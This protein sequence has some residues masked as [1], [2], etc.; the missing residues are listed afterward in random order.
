MRKLLAVA[1]AGAAVLVP[2]SS[3]SAYV[4]CVLATPEGHQVCVNPPCPAGTVNDLDRKLLGDV[5]NDWACLA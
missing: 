2:V 4:I 1:L 3:A 5:L